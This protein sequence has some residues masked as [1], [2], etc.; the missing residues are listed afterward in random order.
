M[1]T[2]KYV[3]IK[4]LHQD[5]SDGALKTIITEINALKQLKQHPN[6]I[7]LYDYDEKVYEKQSSKENRLVNFIAI[8]LAQGGELFNIVAQ[9]GRFDD[10]LSR[11][12]FR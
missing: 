7:H 4:I 6:I 9:T 8:E 3:A 5:I 1:E 2:G 10:Q 12:Y 11:F